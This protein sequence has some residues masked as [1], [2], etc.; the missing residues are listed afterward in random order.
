LDWLASL[1]DPSLCEL[2]SNSLHTTGLL[3]SERAHGVPD[4]LAPHL[5]RSIFSEIAWAAEDLETE[6]QRGAFRF[7]HY[8]LVRKASKGDDG[9]DFP[10]VEDEI[11]FN[12]AQLRIEF[13]TDG[14]QGDFADLQ[15]HRY[16]LVLSAQS[17]P[18][19][20]REV[21]EMFGIDEGEYAHEG[22][23]D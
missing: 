13:H 2:L 17:V 8:V 20:R 3:I 12:H 9:L 1:G 4:A 18:L 10:L 5:C 21:N 11:I 14:E 6:D 23:A 7:T 22:Q 16:V 19:V 15:Y